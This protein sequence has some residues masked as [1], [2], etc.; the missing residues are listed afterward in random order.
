M[1][2]NKCCRSGYRASGLVLRLGADAQF[3]RLSDRCF[4]HRSL[5]IAGSDG[6]LY[7]RVRAF[8]RGAGT[9]RL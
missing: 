2:I 6:R 5:G 9:R 7:A 8:D 1:E 3:W 4:Q